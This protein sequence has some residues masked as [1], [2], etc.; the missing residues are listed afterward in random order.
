MIFLYAAPTGKEGN[1]TT[2][3]PNVR[4]R[5]LKSIDLLDNKGRIIS[6]QNALSLIILHFNVFYGC[7]LMSPM[8]S[9]AIREQSERLHSLSFI[10]APR[11]PQLKYISVAIL[12]IMHHKD[13]A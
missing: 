11:V 10:N 5:L 7:S 6:T 13:Y 9:S 2:F 12:L 4:T 8:S 3:D 1:Y